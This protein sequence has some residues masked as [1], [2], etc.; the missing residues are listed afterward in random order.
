MKS[1]QLLLLVLAASLSVL[2]KA[3]AQTNTATIHAPQGAACLDLIEGCGRLELGDQS[4]TLSAS[5]LSRSLDGGIEIQAVAS[6]KNSRE[7]ETNSAPIT[8][9]IP[10]SLAPAFSLPKQDTENP[11]ASRA[12][13]SRPL[14]CSRRPEAKRQFSMEQLAEALMGQPAISE[15]AALFAKGCPR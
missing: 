11:S 1:I 2:P 12:S 7:L 5:Q 15:Q 8:I 6:W 3:L 10:K 9:V 14:T 4:I 13:D